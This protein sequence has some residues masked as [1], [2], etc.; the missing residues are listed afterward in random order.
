MFSWKN[1]RVA[2]DVILML[3]VSI[4]SS[5]NSQ[6]CGISM[7]KSKKTSRCDPNG[8]KTCKTFAKL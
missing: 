3:M 5:E 6:F 2:I 1:I 8:S 4:K 7:I